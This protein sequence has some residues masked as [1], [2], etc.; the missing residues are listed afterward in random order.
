MPGLS[1]EDIRRRAYELWRAAGEPSGRMDT[2]WYEAEKQ[3]LAERSAQ[4][5]VPPGMTDNLPV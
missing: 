2:F 3:L 4:G 5:E 1:E